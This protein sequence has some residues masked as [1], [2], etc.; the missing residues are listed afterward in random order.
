MKNTKELINKFQSLKGVSFISLNNYK[1]K[2]TGEIANH[3]INVNL[4]VYNAKQTDFEK[5]SNC[6]DENLKEIA[7]KSNIAIEVCKLALQELLSS[8]EK[9]LSKDP[10][11]RSTQS[12][13]QS[14]TYINL[15][16]A[17]RLHKETCE[18]H[19]FGQAINKTVLVKGEYKEV[20]SNDKTLAK[21]AIKKYLDLRSDKF[22][23]F[24]IG[25]VDNIK[26]NKDSIDLI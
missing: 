7:G 10:D 25:N 3:I 4:S 6:N 22:R 24:I 11:E 12:K 14:D 16:P 5:L 2:S 21:N 17:I 9:N 26:V 18:L 20:K 1:S 19:I 8:A 15:T 23:D 13:A